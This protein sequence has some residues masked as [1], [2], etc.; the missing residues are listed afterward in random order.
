MTSGSRLT[1]ASG[2][3]QLRRELLAVNR[4][5]SRQSAVVLP[6]DGRWDPSLGSGAEKGGGPAMY[7]PTAS[8]EV[9]TP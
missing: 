4:A 5:G 2:C 7:N 9:V 8:C 6:A 1:Q 3:R